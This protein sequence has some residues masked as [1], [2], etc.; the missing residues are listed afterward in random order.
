M[1]SLLD[2]ALIVTQVPD[3]WSVVNGVAPPLSINTAVDL[4]KLYS[5][6]TR[7]ERAGV[8]S[9]DLAIWLLNMAVSVHHLPDPPDGIAPAC[10]D[11]LLLFPE[12]CSDAIERLVLRDV[13]LSSSVKGLECHLLWVR[14]NLNLARPKKAWLVMRRA[15][16]LGELV[17]LSHSIDRI[18]FHCSHDDDL[19]KASI[20]TGLAIIDKYSAVLFN[21]K[22]ITEGCHEILP[23]TLAKSYGSRSIQWALSEV[24]ASLA[25][26][27]RH[28]KVG[29]LSEQLMEEEIEVVSHKLDL[30]AGFPRPSPDA[31][32]H[33]MAMASYVYHFLQLCNYLPATF[34]PID[35]HLGLWSDE[36]KSYRYSCCEAAHRLAER[37]I[38]LS[39]SPGLFDA[40]RMVD[41]PAFTAAVVLLL[42]EV[43]TV[44]QIAPKPRQHF[45]IYDT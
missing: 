5:D 38:A 14:L 1:P 2:T 36:A 37:Y 28:W 8:A 11:E 29:H 12:I 35:P 31:S 45:D 39:Q 43:C 23:E 24:A 20:W 13:D 22:S 16:S 6:Y 9:L 33:S 21:L 7:K 34:D 44:S 19:L 17:G 41:F 3:W 18:A 42:Y 30:Y 15:L 40:I 27:D 26:R 32:V 25:R 4:L 10:W